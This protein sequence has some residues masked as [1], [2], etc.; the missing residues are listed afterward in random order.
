M[1]CTFE[2]GVEKKK[3]GKEGSL[4][5]NCLS[6]TQEARLFYIVNK[7]LQIIKSLKHK[8]LF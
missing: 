5:A 3:L 4:G 7:L 8:N 1:E 2:L 6:S